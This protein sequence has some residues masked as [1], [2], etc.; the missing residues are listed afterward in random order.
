MGVQ[1]SETVS[2]GY[3]FYGVMEDENAKIRKDILSIMH[4]RLR[5]RMSDRLI[6][7]QSTGSGAWSFCCFCR[8]A[9][10]RF[11]ADT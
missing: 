10:N 7:M 3:K 1:H 11:A 9:T 5:N 2:P 8:A 4:W 6:I